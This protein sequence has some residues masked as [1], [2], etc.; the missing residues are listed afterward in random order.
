[1]AI[2]KLVLDRQAVA[3]T[4]A[5]GTTSVNEEALVTI[6]KGTAAASTVVL[7]VKGS[8]SVAGDLNLTGN[9]NITGNV[10]TQ[11]VT[12]TN[13]AD[14]TITLNDGGTTPS[15]DTSGII[16]EGTGNSII[17]ALKYKAASATKWSVGTGASQD[18]VVGATATQT[19]TNKTLTSPAINTPTGIVKGDVGLGNVDNTSDV[20]KPVSTAQATSIATKKTDSMS[21]N[22]LLGRGTAATGAIEE[23][24]LGTGLALTGNTLNVTTSTAYQRST[25]VSGTQDSANKIFTI[26]NT[27][28]TGSEQVFINGQLLMP[29]ASNDYVYNGT[30]TVTFQAGFTAPSATDVIRI[31]GCW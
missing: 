29:G 10:N 8:A 11:S 30:T 4:F 1:M 13:V 7:D 28:L 26:A 27:L 6:N 22:K 20:N 23:I 18:D 19:L 15:D 31:Y 24:T 12:N 14:I 3:K 9:L 17:G 21:T 5:F 2:T 25:V 16:I